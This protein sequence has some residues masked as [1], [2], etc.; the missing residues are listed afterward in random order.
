MILHIKNVIIIKT[1]IIKNKTKL[2]PCENRKNLRIT[3]ACIGL[4]RDS[5]F[6]NIWF[7][8]YIKFFPDVEFLHDYTQVCND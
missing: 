3:R 4:Q 2:L 6:R 5:A 1:I 8:P 7:H